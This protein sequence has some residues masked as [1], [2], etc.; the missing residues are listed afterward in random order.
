M[1]LL[2]IHWHPNPKELRCFAIIFLIA[3]MFISSLLYVLGKLGMA[4]A[5]N[6]FLVGVVVFLSSKISLKPVRIIYLVFTVVALPIGWVV[7]FLLL[8]AFYFLLLSPLALIFRLAGRDAL[9]RRFDPN[10]DSYWIAQ[11][12]S[13]RPDR[14]FHQF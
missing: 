7:S 14:Y 2:E 10:A 4:W 3:T 12:Q 13:D 9:R 1:S 6:I 11:R 8:A 5:S